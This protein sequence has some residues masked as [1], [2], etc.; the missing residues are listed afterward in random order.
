MPSVM[1][2]LSDVT[3]AASRGTAMAPIMATFTLSSIVGPLL[4]GALT[5]L[6]DGGWRLCFWI[7]VPIGVVAMLCI[8]FL[9]PATLGD[10]ASKFDV[11]REAA[12]VMSGAKRV[13]AATATATAGAAATAPAPAPGG[14]ADEAAPAVVVPAEPKRSAIDLDV[15]G[16]VCAVCGITALSL[17]ITWG[18]GDYSWSDPRV[19]A[20]L[21]VALV[22]GIVFSVWETHFATAPIMPFRLFAVRNFWVA[23]WIMFFGGFAMTC[24]STQAQPPALSTRQPSYS[25]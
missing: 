8:F 17:A 10:Q 15:V 16:S 12:G 20:L 1:I 4:G 2:V 13:T 6:Y 23:N 5:D 14:V 21:I 18:G 7:N 9:L 19:F 3:P 11:Q 22:L 25:P 24:T